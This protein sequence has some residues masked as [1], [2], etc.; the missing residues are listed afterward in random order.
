MRTLVPAFNIMRFYVY[1]VASF[2]CCNDYSNYPSSIGQ[3][4]ANN[5]ADQ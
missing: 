3:Y 5:T 1:C 4:D 2:Y